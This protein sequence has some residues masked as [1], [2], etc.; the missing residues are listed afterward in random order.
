MPYKKKYATEEERRLALSKAGKRG[1][2]QTRKRGNFKGGRPKGS[3]NKNPSVSEPTH[4]V[5]VRESAYK[6]FVKCAGFINKSLVEFM[7][8]VAHGLKK[9]NPQLFELNDQ[10]RV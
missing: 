3:R 9:K 6:I 5:L 2:E 7:S 8:I 1:A 4:S 10:V